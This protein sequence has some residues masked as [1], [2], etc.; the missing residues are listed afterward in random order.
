MPTVMTLTKPC[1]CETQ[2]RASTIWQVTM[3]GISGNGN[4][5]SVH[6]FPLRK[7]YILPSTLLREPILL[8]FWRFA[9][10]AESSWPDFGCCSPVECPTSNSPRQSRRNTELQPNSEL[11]NNGNRA[12]HGVSLLCLRA[13]APTPSSKAWRYQAVWFN[14]SMPSMQQRILRKAQRKLR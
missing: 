12:A 8:Q 5:R 1:R 7:E 13:D 2:S 10:L 9:L 6:S 3:L 11:N 4:P 14:A